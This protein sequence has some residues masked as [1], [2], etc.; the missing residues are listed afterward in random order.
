MQLVQTSGRCSLRKPQIEIVTQCA[1]DFEP[2]KKIPTI[3]HH[4]WKHSWKVL[5]KALLES[6]NSAQSERSRIAFDEKVEK[7]QWRAGRNVTLLH[8][9]NVKF[10]VEQ[11]LFFVSSNG[12]QANNA[13][14]E[15]YTQISVF[16]Q[17]EGG[18]SD[19]KDKK[20]QALSISIGQI[21][22]VAALSFHSIFEVCS[23]PISLFISKKNM[24]SSY[25]HIYIIL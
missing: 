1:S 10:K 24:C 25:A 19:Q 15:P 23:L 17:M 22:T 8:Q 3:R 6:E 12:E 4:Y 11:N 16:N 14:A 13:N 21:I 18:N 9:E 5:S 7:A 20:P 2:P